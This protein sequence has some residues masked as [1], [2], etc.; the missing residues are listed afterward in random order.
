V[1]NKTLNAAQEV[2]IRIYENIYFY[3]SGDIDFAKQLV[4]ANLKFCEYQKIAE[5]NPQAQLVFDIINACIK[6][7]LYE[8]SLP[9]DT[10]QALENFQKGTLAIFGR[11]LMRMVPKTKAEH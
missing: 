11:L 8:K 4:S 10:M 9:D 3:L 7:S 1:H 6:A 5:R 2:Q